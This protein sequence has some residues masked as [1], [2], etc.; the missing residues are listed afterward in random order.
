LALQHHIDVGAGVVDEDFRGNLRVVLLNHSDKAFNVS[1]GD[2]T[3]QLI[4]E[5]IYY[6]KLKEVKRLNE[7]ERNKYGFGSTGK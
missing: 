5:K 3:A 1:C 2:R 4:C 6:P 7:A